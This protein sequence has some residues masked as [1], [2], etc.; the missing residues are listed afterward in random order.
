MNRPA[1][2]V[3]VNAAD[4][5]WSVIGLRGDRSCPE[6]SKH[7]HCR[8]CPTYSQIAATLLE[9]AAPDGPG[10]SAPSYRIDSAA[11]GRSTDKSALVFRLGTEWLAIPLNALDEVV[12]LRAIHS[13][14]HR[15]NPVL[16]GLVNNRGELVV[17]VSLSQLIGVEPDP[18]AESR[19]QR[20]LILRSGSGR[21]AVPVDEVQQTFAYDDTDLLALPATISP[22][23]SRYTT[24]LL[25][26]PDRVVGRIDVPAMID[27]FD[28]CLA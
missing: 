19:K 24:D 20:L 21:L 10:G 4:S 3:P 17:C 14:P 25:R 28:R 2:A 1:P 23:T 27:A 16:L 18:P 13:V 26:C 9:R 5:C 7:S 12:E 6:L 22:A 8:N 11:T 15:P